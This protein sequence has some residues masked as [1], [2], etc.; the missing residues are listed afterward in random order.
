M[1]WVSPQATEFLAITEDKYGWV[2]HLIGVLFRLP[3][4]RGLSSVLRRPLS[5]FFLFLHILVWYS[6]CIFQQTV[7]F[8]IFP[9][10]TFQWKVQFSLVFGCCYSKGPCL[11]HI[12]TLPQLWS[13]MLST[14]KYSAGILLTRNTATIKIFPRLFYYTLTL[15]SASPAL[16]HL[17]CLPMRQDTW[18]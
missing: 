11:T 10:L 9:F 4:Q 2:N 8:C 6:S 17:S 13:Q 3:L 7:L 18:H 15:Q 1:E 16:Q 12:L 5:F 14:L